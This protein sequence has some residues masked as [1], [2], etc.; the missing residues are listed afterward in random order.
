MRT[1]FVPKRL[2]KSLATKVRCGAGAR[3]GRDQRYSPRCEENGGTTDARRDE[4]YAPAHDDPHGAKV[5]GS[6]GSGSEVAE[7]GSV[8]AKWTVEGK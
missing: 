3:A 6:R 2:S 4:K 1:S 7:R 8:S 5:P